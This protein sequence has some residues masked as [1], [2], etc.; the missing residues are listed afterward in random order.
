MIMLAPPRTLLVF[1]LLAW[2]V[3]TAV[4]PIWL[5]VGMLAGAADIAIT[6][7]RITQETFRRGPGMRPTFTSKTIDD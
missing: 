6:W 1:R 4:L 5:V 7:G 3:V 2:L